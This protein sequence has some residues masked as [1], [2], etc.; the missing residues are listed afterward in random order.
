MGP[1]DQVLGL[2]EILKAGKRLLKG[3]SAGPKREKLANTVKH[4]V[5]Y[6]PTAIRQRI[7]YREALQHCSEPD[8]N[9]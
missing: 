8:C 7:T 4:A 2:T 3:A 6:N 1:I 9:R 5:E